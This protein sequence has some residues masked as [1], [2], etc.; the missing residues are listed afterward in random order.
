MKLDEK[1]RQI[2]GLVKVC[3]EEINKCET[4][5]SDKSAS[6]N[7]EVTHDVMRHNMNEKKR[8]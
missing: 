8:G 1:R 7:G 5:D 6:R 2:K 4:D 3:F